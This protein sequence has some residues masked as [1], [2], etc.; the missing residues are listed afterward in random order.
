MLEVQDNIWNKAAK[1]KLII[2]EEG[3]ESYFLYLVDIITV[4]ITFIIFFC[5]L[6]T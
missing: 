4:I 5:F 1:N 3:L 6:D 2:Q